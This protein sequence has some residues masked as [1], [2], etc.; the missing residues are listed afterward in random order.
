MLSPNVGH[1]DLL[2]SIVTVTDLLSSCADLHSLSKLT[3]GIARLR[4]LL[5]SSDEAV[6]SF[7]ETGGFESLLKTIETATVLRSET[8]YRETD[9][10]NG[11]STII[12]EERLQIQK[13]LLQLA[14]STLSLTMS[15]SPS[16]KEYFAQ[17]Q[18]YAQIETLI[19]SS[20]V[21]SNAA[22]RDCVFGTLFAGAIH[23]F[24]HCHVFSSMR[25]HLTSDELSQRERFD[26]IAF[27]MQ[28]T[29]EW[30]EQLP[31][32]EFICII[33]ALL[34]E[35]REDQDLGLAVCDVLR[36]IVNATRA[37]Q[38][39]FFESNAFSDIIDK[40]I[41]GSPTWASQNLSQE[42]IDLLEDLIFTLSPL[43]LPL[44]LAS[45]VVSS[46]VQRTGNPSD[47]SLLP[48]LQQFTTQSRLPPHFHFDMHPKSH[49]AITFAA[50]SAPF[51]PIS[52][53]GYT[54][55]IWFRIEKFDPEMHVTLFGAFDTTQKSFCMAYIEQDTHKLVLQ[56]SLRSSVR[57]K[58]F[59]FQSG[60]WYHLTLTHRRAR[61]T[62]SARAFLFVDGHLTDQ[63]KCSYPTTP[64]QNSPLQAFFGT[65]PA[66]ANQNTNPILQWSLAQAH[67]WT[68]LLP[69]DLIDVIFRLGPRYRGNFQDSLGQFQTYDASTALNIRLA[70][71]GVPKA[72]K[73]VL[74]ATVRGKGGQW[75][76]ETRLL[77]AVAAGAQTDIPGVLNCSEPRMSD[78]LAMESG[79]GETVGGVVLVKPRSL[80]DTVWCLG[81]CAIGLRMVEKA[82]TAEEVLDSVR[83]LFE[84]I[85]LSW[86]NSEDMERCHGYEILA[87]LLRGKKRELIT[88][89]VLNVISEFI[90][91]D[92]EDVRFIVEDGGNVRESTVA[93]PL[94]FRYLCLDFGIWKRA[95][96]ETQLT[97][98][99]ILLSLLEQSRHRV[100]NLRRLN[101]MRTLPSCQINIRYREENVVCIAIRDVFKGH[102]PLIY[103]PPK[104]TRQVQ[105]FNRNR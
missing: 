60:R 14:F 28:A 70:S 53:G 68:D 38:S 94:A 33:M 89:E 93:N 9:G 61:A 16:S 30:T 59:E 48:I 32:P 97:H 102:P 65:P 101:K 37:N 69:E 22:L 43:G 79:V 47:Q 51:P 86:R 46:A 42:Q 31:H 72:E 92:F 26:R 64:P 44:P 15:L 23:D 34:P 13:E 2:N 58:I 50:L 1:P 62:S 29:F 82:A 96:T 56:T 12:A 76:P 20:R 75:A 57:F 80:D 40:V 19:R 100:F 98:L 39:T 7:A 54:L 83:V 41:L 63:I 87:F 99:Q 8:E 84:F 21:L 10:V 66:F 73:S 77:L 78:A 71:M 91:V 6:E 74:M 4:E 5:R 24:T 90:G 104:R 11:N 88:I 25:W 35:V 52:T 103:R 18:G 3:E 45:A 55:S 95:N 67:L 17:I 85:R 49:A 27:K 81:G 36:M 105:L